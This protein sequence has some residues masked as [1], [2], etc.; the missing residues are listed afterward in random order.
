MTYVRRLDEEDTGLPFLGAVR[1]PRPAPP[2]RGW[3][4]WMTGNELR[5]FAVR[6]VTVHASPPRR[7]A[8]CVPHDD[9]T[10][11]GGSKARA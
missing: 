6:R 8:Y 7:T 2:L 10:S 3:P 4:G 9:G 1:D 11:R 5:R